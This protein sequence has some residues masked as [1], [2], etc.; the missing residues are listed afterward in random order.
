MSEEH[1]EGLTREE[2][3]A[4]AALR[5]EP[6]PPSGLEDRVVERLAAHGL[7]A[8]EQGVLA[9]LAARCRALPLAPRMGFAMVALAA[10][11]VLGVQVGRRADAPSVPEAVLEPPPAVSGEEV[12]GGMILVAGWESDGAETSYVQVSS[13]EKPFPGD[14]EAGDF[15]PYPLDG[16]IRPYSVP[17]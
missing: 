14:E 7:I 1:R 17:R 2:R 11:F 8:R 10:T 4:Y 6:G 9:A 16:E 3:A 12:D 13:A 5:S 15:R